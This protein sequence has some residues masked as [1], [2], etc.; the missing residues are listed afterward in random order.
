MMDEVF[1]Q[2]FYKLERGGS[3]VMLQLSTVTI[4][5]IDFVLI[6]SFS[7]ITNH[8]GRDYVANER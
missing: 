1:V 8:G 4:E 3:F 2:K 7:I 6:S 5:G